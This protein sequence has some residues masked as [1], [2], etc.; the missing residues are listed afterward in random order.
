VVAHC[1]PAAPWSGERRRVAAAAEH[2]AKT[3]DCD[4]L[5]CLRDDSGSA[6]IVRKALRPTAPPYAA[7]FQ[8]P[9]AVHWEDYDLIWVYDLWGMTCV[10]N[11]VHSRVI[12]D[13]DT[14]MGSSY[15]SGP[16]RARLLAGWVSAYERRTLAGVTHAF[17]S[18]PSDVSRIGLKHVT[19]VPHGFSGPVRERAVADLDGRTLRMGFVGLL[20][21]EPNRRALRWFA[22]HIW[23]DVRRTESLRDAELWVAGW[24]LPIEDEEIIGRKAG[25]E[26]CGYVADL[27][28][29]YAS[30]DLMIAPL[31]YGE[32][33]PTKVVEAL[34]HGLP[35]VGTESGFRGLQ[36]DQRF[37]CFNAEKDGWPEAVTAALAA[38]GP[39]AA[40]EW[41]ESLTWSRVFERHVDPVLALTT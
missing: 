13:K 29:F 36:P 21:H 4:V 24:G 2:L 31:L 28:G 9:T 32:G 27:D 11:C 18:L 38:R 15:S 37:G 25:I 14:L 35:V 34:G 40:T 16:L 33:A 7:R 20:G 6:R 12:W 8:P 10:P 23:P 39:V 26:L 3:Y 1:P 17:L 5:I 41:R 30:V 22:E 19:C